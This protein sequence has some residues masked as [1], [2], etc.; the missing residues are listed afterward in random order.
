MRILIEG[1]NREGY[2]AKCHEAFR[3]GLRVL[4]DTR[5]FGEGYPGYC[6]SVKSYQEIICKVFP[7]ADPDILIA[8]PTSKSDLGLFNYEGITNVNM[9]TVSFLCDYWRAIDKVGRDEFV[10]IIQ[11]NGINYVITLFPQPLEIWADTPLSEKL[12]YLPPC[13]DPKIFND[14]QM[15]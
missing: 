12:I 15:E 3:T 5:C 7:D 14:W 10:K 11:E 8:G 6:S 13:F 4:F 1:E 9:P 2:L